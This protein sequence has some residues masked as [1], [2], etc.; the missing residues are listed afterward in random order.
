MSTADGKRRAARERNRRWRERHPEYAK[1]ASR[2]AS[3]WNRRNREHVNALRRK[4]YAS[5]AGEKIRARN[6]DYYARN[7]E[8]QKAQNR[9]W[10]LANKAWVQERDRERARA[11]Y[12]RDPA[13]WQAYLKSWRSKNLDLAHAYVRASANRR[14]RAI[15]LDNSQPPSGSLL[16]PNTKEDAH[17]AARRGRLKSITGRRSVVADQTLS[18]TSCRRVGHVTVESTGRPRLNSARF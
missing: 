12:R 4:R 15:G 6:R 10:R 18:T 2:Q 7:R 3:A 9:I 5:S 11:R 1:I 14:K 16:S 17:T 8:R 13:A